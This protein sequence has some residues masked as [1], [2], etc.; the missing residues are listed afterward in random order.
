MILAAALIATV[1]AGC[2][3]SSHS[4]TTGTTIGLRPR[5]VHGHTIVAK[6]PGTTGKRET[7]AM[8]KTAKVPPRGLRS[9]LVGFG[10][11]LPQKLQSMAADVSGVWQRIFQLAGAQLTSATE[12]IVDQPPAS[13]GS[14]SV[15][16]SDPPEYCLADAS[17]DLP[18]GYFGSNVEPLGDAATLLLVSDTYGFHVEDALQAFNAGYSDATLKEIA[19]C[20][21]GIIFE[22]SLP[23]APSPNNP[24][25]PYLQPKDLD[26][27]NAELAREAGASGAPSSSG[28][29]TAAEL[30][31]AF[32]RGVGAGIQYRACLPAAAGG[33][34]PTK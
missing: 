6:L 19:S 13:C 3:S 10:G 22:Q 7:L 34:L 21:S 24:S 33:T 20:L 16:S 28:S 26:S 18:V 27:V 23:T 8:L 1:L 29:V 12:N 30:T 14:R 9:H 32:N 2:G 15:T 31:A 25:A 4:S 11:P 17:V 5:P